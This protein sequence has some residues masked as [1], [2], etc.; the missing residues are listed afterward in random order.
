MTEADTTAQPV[1]PEHFDDTRTVRE[2]P[3]TR[4]SRREYVQETAR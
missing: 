2:M 1:D 4:V 3:P